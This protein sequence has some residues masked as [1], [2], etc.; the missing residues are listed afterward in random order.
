MVRLVVWG[1]LLA[2]CVALA[3]AGAAPAARSSPQAKAERPAAPGPAAPAGQPDSPAQAVVKALDRPVTLAVK[4]APLKD[5]LAKLREQTGVAFSLR[6]EREDELPAVTCDRRKAPLRS[7]LRAALDGSGLG[8]A[9]VGGAVV[10]DDAAALAKHQF[11]QEVDLDLDGVE[12]GVALKQLA[13]RTAVNLVLDARAAKEAQTPVTFH[14]RDV[15]LE[16]AVRLLADAAGL[17][18]I[19]LDNVLYVTTEPRATALE[20]ERTGALGRGQANLLGG[21]G[22]LGGF[23]GQ[24]F[25]GGLAGGGAY[26]GRYSPSG[27]LPVVLIDVGGQNVPA[28]K[29]APGA[30]P[31]ARPAQPQPPPK[32]PEGKP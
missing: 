16:T 9:V 18:Q 21:L 8:Y 22:A 26:Q 24:G 28:I 1:G 29:P 27:G 32:K 13:R 6:G 3:W 5:V 19:L 30:T 20:A 2:A 25:L 17:K 11:T 14:L 10:I 23:G 4:E 15:P 31:P 7:V 12:V